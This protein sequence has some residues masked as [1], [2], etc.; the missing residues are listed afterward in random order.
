MI[1]FDDVWFEYEPNQPVLQNLS[2][3]IK[4]GE[5]VAL[6]GEN[7]AGKTTLVKH[8]NGLLKPT[9]GTVYLEGVD[10]RETSTAKLARKVGFVFQN[11]DH[12]LFADTLQAEIGFALRNLDFSKE[13]I[14]ERVTR[15]LTLFEL[16][17]YHDQSPFLLSGGERKRL[18]LA[19]VLCV[20]PQILILDEPT[21]AQDALQKQKLL[22]FI[23]SFRQSNQILLLVTHDVEF[24]VKAVDRIVVLSQGEL[25]ADGTPRQILN[26]VS[27]LERARLLPPQLTQF[28]HKLAG[29]VPQFP[30]DILTLPEAVKAVNKILRR[31]R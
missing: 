29:Q 25:I 10:T 20:E 23:E 6:M 19:S 15:F 12:Q 2:L 18:A 16:T 14:N 8:I 21:Q 22:D 4:P 30:T 27:I 28:A 24:A 17:K 7:G 11:A 13:E 5:T 9:R 26:N 1:L 3:Q 31:P